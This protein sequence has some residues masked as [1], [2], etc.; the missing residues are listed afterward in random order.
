[1]K[2]IVGLGNPG[3]EYKGT[4]HNVGFEVVDELA[5]RWKTTLK[6]WKSI[7]D[8]AIVKEHDAVLVEPRTYMNNSGSA[9]QAVM[10][11][12]KITP[13]DVLVIVDEVQLP[14]A[15]LRLRPSGS[16][17][18]HNGLKSVI[19]HVGT[20]FTRLRIG[21]ERGDRDRDLADRVLSRFD[22][23]ERD[24]IDRAVQRAADAVELFIV[25]GIGPAMNRFNGAED[26]TLLGD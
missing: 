9:V 15:K 26:N 11:F 18:G 8:V 3:S 24:A 6:K 12:Y 14:L 7:A 5:R 17:G 20:D 4:R 21:V 19:E 13:P 10:T 25:E 2:A 22:S 16:A 1:M 23:S